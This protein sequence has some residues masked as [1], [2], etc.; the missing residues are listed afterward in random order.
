MTY[1]P[2]LQ[3]RE[4]V[5]GQQHK[6]K[7]LQLTDIMIEK[8]VISAKDDNTKN[9]VKIF[10]SYVGNKIFFNEQ[11]GAENFGGAG[12]QNIFKAS[13]LIETFKINTFQL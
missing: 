9:T 6:I 12:V 5:I 11:I 7:L 2:H 1:T 10:T 13:G 4:V 8:D 3:Y